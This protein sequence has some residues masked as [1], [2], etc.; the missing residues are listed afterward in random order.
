[1]TKG[2]MT[3]ILVLLRELRRAL[4]LGAGAL[5]VAITELKGDSVNVGKGHLTH[6]GIVE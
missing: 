5:K 6:N 2:E 1:M 4:L 3:V